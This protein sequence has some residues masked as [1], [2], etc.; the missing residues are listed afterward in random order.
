MMNTEKI[1]FTVVFTLLVQIVSAQNFYLGVDLS[2]V[3]ELEDCGTKYYNGENQVDPYA[4]LESIGAN[5][6]RLRLWH[7]PSWT[8]YSNLEDV[9][10]SIARA[11]AQGMAVLLDFHYSDFWTDPGRQWRPEAWNDIEDDGVMGDSVYQYTYETLNT[12]ATEGLLPDIVQLGNETNG[13][14]L[15][16]RSG[17]G[18]SGK[19][20]GLFPVN[21]ERQ[22]AIFDKGN[23]AVQKINRDSSFSIKT[24][25][26]IAQPEN[27]EWWFREAFEKGLEEFDIIGISYYP[28]YSSYDPRQIGESISDWKKK[29]NKEVMIVEIAFPWTTGFNDS[30]PN[31]YG[32]GSRIDT[33]GNS[34]SQ[35]KQRDFMTELTYIVKES[36]GL[37]VVYWEPA[38]VSSSCKTYWA[39][40]SNVE[41]SALFDFNNKLHVGADFL[42]YDYEVMPKGLR[43]KNVTF[44][45]D[46]T[47]VNTENGVYVTGSFTG[48]NWRLE[49][50]SLDE[51]GLYVF[52][53]KIPGRTRGS[54]VFYND[55]TWNTS[56]KEDVPTSCAKIEGGFRRFLI[57]DNEETYYFAWES[58]STQPGNVLSLNDQFE[59]N[60]CITYPTPASEKLYFCPG[61]FGD[62]Y[63]IA[64]ISG[65]LFYKDKPVHNYIDI[66]QLPVGIY[67][68]KIKRG[69][70][71]LYTRFIK[72]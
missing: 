55:T 61:F 12:L 26:H 45:V 41:N 30:A 19:S 33:Y 36:G 17:E 13:N 37:G 48:I 71:I 60:S 62:S 20:P 65:Q 50:M 23:E 2:Y 56:D 44:I 24:L 72:E 66:S 47:G 10:K 57:M 27:A 5:I 53:T 16:R 15:I 52:T 51:K 8:N 3:N 58:C 42:S 54:Y 63:A 9:K 14:S 21:W 28:Q 43:E 67:I 59:A 68:L 6:V 34:F 64:G 38:W 46:M 70:K 4:Q 32:N 1:F 25:I 40:G 69:S 35:E 49:E 18:I 11:K 7:N 29:Y 31:L 22:I 39:T